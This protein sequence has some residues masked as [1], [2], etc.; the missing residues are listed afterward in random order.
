MPPRLNIRNK[1]AIEASGKSVDGRTMG[2]ALGDIQNGVGNI[3]NRLSSD[4]S[5]STVVPP[6]V[7]STQ[8]VHL[9][10]GFVDVS[11]TDNSPNTTSA[12]AYHLE[13]AD[14]PGF[15]GSI[16]HG[17]GP[18]RNHGRILLPNG[19][20][21]FKSYSQYQYGGPPG[22]GSTTG[23]VNVTGSLLGSSSLLPTQGS[24][25][26]LPGQTGVGFGRSISR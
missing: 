2:E 5:G 26:G 10:N 12:V 23:P 11:S 21:W 1:S 6:K 24:G 25:S 22:E 8:A 14:N 16:Y 19:K 7:S 17:G 20:W 3:A 18:S 15:N 9:G 4:P 13:Y